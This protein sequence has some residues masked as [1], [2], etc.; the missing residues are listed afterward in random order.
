MRTT[1]FTAALGTYHHFGIPY[2][3]GVLHHNPDTAVELI[4]D[5]P[6]AF[7][8]RY[9]AAIAVLAESFGPNRFHVRSGLPE[10]LPSQVRFLLE[11]EI[12]SDYVYIGDVDILVLQPDVVEQHIG[13]MAQSLMPYS[14]IQRP[15]RKRLSGLHFT[16]WDAYYPVGA[17]DQ[18]TIRSRADEAILY[19]LIRQRGL[20]PAP[21]LGR[22]MHGIHMSPNRTKVIAVEGGGV[23][24]GVTAPVW[25]RYRRFAASGF[26]QQIRPLFHADYEALLQKLEME[27]SAAFGP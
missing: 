9:R 14:N 21:D 10:A 26:W 22:P 7:S 19:E 23:C 15:G 27:G 2:A 20:L 3:A 4:V 24:W 16:R 17:L 6:T 11:P 13:K 1:F 8:E 5:D 18:K 25:E 12:K